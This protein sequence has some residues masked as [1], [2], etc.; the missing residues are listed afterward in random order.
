MGIGYRQ[1]ANVVCSCQIRRMK[2]FARLCRFVDWDLSKTGG[3]RAGDFSLLIGVAVIGIPLPFLSWPYRGGE[4]V[5]IFVAIA[6]FLAWSWFVGWRAWRLFRASGIR[7]DRKYDR[8]GKFE[9]PAEYASTESATQ[10]A[11]RRGK[12]HPR[13]AR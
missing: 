7:G 5:F 12:R 13:N 8:E 11:R 10:A 9:L 2:R 3:V 4:A 6:A 1:I